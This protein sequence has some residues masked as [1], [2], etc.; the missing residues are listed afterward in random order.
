MKYPATY[1]LGLFVFSAGSSYATVLFQNSADLSNFTTANTNGSTARIL[2][3]NGSTTPVSTLDGDALRF[4]D[5]SNTLQPALRHQTSVALSDALKVSFDVKIASVSSNIVFRVGPDASLLGAASSSSF[6]VQLTNSGTIATEQ[7]PSNVNYTSSYSSAT[8]FNLTMFYN[9]SD[10]AID[11]TAHN[12]P[13]SLGSHKWAL[14]VDGTL[15]SS[16]L[17]E[18]SS[19]TYGSSF[20]FAWLSGTSAGA[21]AMDFQLDNIEFTNISAIPEPS[22]AA[23]L[24]GSGALGFVAFG[25]RRR[26]LTA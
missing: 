2:V 21:N 1:L 4:S 6:G 7:S 13:A 25:R 10:S 23:A 24:I 16:A 17:A 8:R 9:N 3:V 12:G 5:T 26:A 15:K 11:L 18:K 22:S 19:Q 14:Y 20:G